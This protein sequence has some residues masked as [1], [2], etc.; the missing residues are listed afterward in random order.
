MRTSKIKLGLL[1]FASS[2]L[3]GCN[4][5]IFYRHD[6]KTGLYEKRNS[7]TLDIF[8]DRVERGVK[9]ESRGEQVKTGWREYWISTA[10]GISS[11]DEGNPE[12]HD[13]CIQYIINQRREAGLP[14][15]PEL[16]EMKYKH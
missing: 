2:L 4:S 8:T 9:R 10:R 12:V 5:F 6:P 16:N 14:D 1:V 15:I 11:W 3:L 13:K 7:Y